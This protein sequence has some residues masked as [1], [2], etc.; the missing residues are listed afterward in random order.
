[1]TPRFFHHESL[2]VGQTVALSDSASFH[3]IKVLR[4]TDASNVVLFNGDAHPYEC[5]LSRAGKQILATVLK[6]GPKDPAPPFQR[7]LAQAL[8]SNEKMAWVIEKAVELG[9]DKIV[10]IRSHGAKVRLDPERGHAKQERWQDIAASACAQCGRNTLVTVEPPTTVI[11]FLSRTSE[12]TTVLFEPG[13]TVSL[14]R[15]LT[16]NQPTAGATLQ[17][18]VGPE[19][20]FS[21]E[22]IEQAKQAGATVVSLGW[23]ILRTETAGLAALAVLETYC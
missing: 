10:P 9:V 12:H 16:Q 5:K 6:Q 14:A 18:M 1:M 3:A 8:L 4:L 23:R 20:G 22:E 17:L 19:S 21:L 11:E 13:A 15:L 2:T 7:V